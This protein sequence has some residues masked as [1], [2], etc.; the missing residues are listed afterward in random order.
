MVGVVIKERKTGSSSTRETIMGL[1]P[2]EKASRFDRLWKSA[3][4]PEPNSG[5]DRFERS[6]WSVINSLSSRIK[7]KSC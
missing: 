7:R 2:K 5:D 3:I 1:L 6:P 4:D